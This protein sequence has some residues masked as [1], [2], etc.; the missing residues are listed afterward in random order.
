MDRGLRELR[1]GSCMR[2]GGER[3]ENLHRLVAQLAMRS[4]CHVVFGLIVDTLG[5]S[6]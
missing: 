6:C 5:K 3:L 1:K 4:I 2:G